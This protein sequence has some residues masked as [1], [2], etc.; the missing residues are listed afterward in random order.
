V[1]A[2]VEISSALEGDRL[3]PGALDHVA[4]FAPLPSHRIAGGNQRLADALARALGERVRLRCPACAVECGEGQVRV[5]TPAGEVRAD[6]LVVAL[7]L[8]V[9]RALPVTPALPGWKREALERVAVGHAAKLHVPLHET[10]P[11]SAV[12]SVPGRFWTWTATA[13]DGAVAPVLNCFAGSPP[14]LD[15][16]AVGD[17]PAA[18]LQRVVELRPDLRLDGERARLTTWS[19]DP[20]AGGAYRADGVDARTGDEERLEAPVGRMHFAGEY[21]AGEWSGLMEGALRSGLRAAAELERHA[22]AAT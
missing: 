17:G 13:G 21:A 6:R 20:L 3:R 14:A 7:P 2:R 10:A 4:A 16:L 5:H 9:L 18:W 1:L 15:A 19:D 22:P 8:P 11:P 12:M